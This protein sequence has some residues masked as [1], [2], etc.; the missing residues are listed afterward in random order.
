LGDEYRSEADTLELVNGDAPR[1]V[2]SGSDLGEVLLYS[3]PSAL[4]G[5]LREAAIDCAD[6]RPIADR[7]D[8]WTSLARSSPL[9]LSSR[10]ITRVMSR[11]VR[12]PTSLKVLEISSAVDAREGDRV[13]SGPVTTTPVSSPWLG[14]TRLPGWTSRVTF[15]LAKSVARTTF[16]PVRSIS[17]TLTRPVKSAAA[18]VAGVTRI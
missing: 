12:A 10:A 7:D 11:S 8:G 14:M 15:S 9:R 13:V 5:R 18:R 17:A 4:A 3:R 1:V 16:H 6:E 2:S